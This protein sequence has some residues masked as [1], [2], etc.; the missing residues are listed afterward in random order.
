M[1]AIRS[2]YGFTDSEFNK[3]KTTLKSPDG[4]IIKEI[5]YSITE[6]KIIDFTLLENRI[7]ISIYHVIV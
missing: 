3:L 6:D 4:K 2:Y 7:V 1:Y 5:N